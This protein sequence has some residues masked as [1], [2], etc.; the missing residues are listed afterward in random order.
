[1]TVTDIRKRLEEGNARYQ[2][3]EIQTKLSADGFTVQGAIYD[4]GTGKATSLD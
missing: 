2:V 3:R 4:V 1:M